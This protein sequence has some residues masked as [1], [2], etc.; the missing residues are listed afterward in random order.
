MPSVKR[1][2]QIDIRTDMQNL[3]EGTKEEVAEGNL[4][5]EKATVSWR[6]IRMKRKL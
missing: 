4:Q 5:L 1:I 2:L 6:S 3:H